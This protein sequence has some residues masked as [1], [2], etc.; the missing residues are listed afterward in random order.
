MTCRNRNQVA[1]FFLYQQLYHFTVVFSWY[2]KILSS[3]FLSSPLLRGISRESAACYQ[4]CIL[5]LPLLTV[6]FMVAC[7]CLTK[8]ST[9]LLSLSPA[10]NCVHLY[11]ALFNIKYQQIVNVPQP[12]KA[13]RLFY[14]NSFTITIKMNK[15]V[16]LV[17]RADFVGEILCIGIHL[18]TL[19]MHYC[20]KMIWS[21]K[22]TAQPGVSSFGAPCRSLMKQQ[23]SL[24][25][26]P[27]GCMSR[28]IQ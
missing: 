23:D 3:P 15:S 5:T 10:E 27:P 8:N 12:L 24:F 1:G 13:P 6:R 7:V 16:C 9:S 17:T 18:H 20:L 19:K 14:C 2:P 11:T 4:L 28:C 26:S 25:I 21:L 22:Q